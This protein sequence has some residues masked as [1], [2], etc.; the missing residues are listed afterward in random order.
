M[1]EVPLVRSAPRGAASRSPGRSL[2]GRVGRVALL[3]VVAAALTGCASSGS[4]SG[5]AFGA[6]NP[7]ASP[8]ASP[9]SAAAP[10]PGA[11]PGCEPYART[12]LY[13]GTS[14]KA[15]SPVSDQEFDAFLD[16]EITPRF[17]DGLTLLPGSGQFR[18]SDGK[19][20]QERSMVVILLYPRKEG[21]EDSKKVD[22]IR[23]LYEQKF[24]QESVLRADEQEGTC[25]SF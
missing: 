2:T 25:V 8:A 12:E 24:N 6:G 13:F 22:E 1:T 11:A 9:P 16:A 20:V 18:G 21:A 3:G 14:R 10:G 19:L 5:G 17:P 4:G 23:D 7:P 15:T